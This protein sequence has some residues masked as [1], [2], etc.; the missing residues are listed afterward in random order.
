MIRRLSAVWQP[1]TGR[2]ASGPARSLLLL[3]QVL[4]DYEHGREESV[5]AE[6]EHELLKRAWRLSPNDFLICSELGK[7]HGEESV[8]YWTTAVASGLIARGLITTSG[9]V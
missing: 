5:F 8:R 2:V 6:Q 1:V 3:V 4:K 7:G 9:L